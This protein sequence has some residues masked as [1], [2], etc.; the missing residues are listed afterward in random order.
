MKKLLILVT[1]HLLVLTIMAQTPEEILIA[2]GIHLPSFPAAVGNYTSLVESGHLL[3]LSGRGPLQ[4]DGK[5][6]VGKLGK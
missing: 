4:P 3:Y 2:K 6:M 5:Y 1:I